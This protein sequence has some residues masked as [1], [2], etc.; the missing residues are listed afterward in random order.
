MGDSVGFYFPPY[1]PRRLK[2]IGENQ[3]TVKEWVKANAKEGANFAEFDE[4]LK[5]MEVPTD[6]TEAKAFVFKNKALLSAFDDEV[7][8]KIEAHD[9]KFKE[10]K[11]PDIIKIEREN[12]MKELHPEETPLE[13]R[14][15]E[16]DERIKWFENEKQINARKEALRKKAAEIGFDPTI[17]ETFAG[18]GDEAENQIVRIN[19]YITN[20]AMSKLEA[21]TKKRFNNP[22]PIYGAGGIKKAVKDMTPDEAMQYAKQGDAQ[23]AEVLAAFKK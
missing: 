14:V 23:R 17:A 9:A 21:E 22:A 20:A 3:M 1:N 6:M 12:I 10:T 15:R 18:F 8:I 16:Q 2:P 4:L 13:K 19:E 11:L 5:S 7:R